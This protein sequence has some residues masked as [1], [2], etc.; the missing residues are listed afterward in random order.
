MENVI[1]VTGS[2]HKADY[3]SRCLGQPVAHQK[4]DVDEIQSLDLHEIV[5]HKVRGA[6][7]KVRQPVI[8]E[9]VSLEFTALGKLPGPFIKWFFQELG[10]EGVCSL[11][12]GK[13]RSATV[14]CV[15]G[16]YDGTDEQ[17]FEG[18]VTGRIAE[19]PHPGTGYGFDPIF[20][21]DGFDAPRSVMNAEDHDRTY[22][23]MKPFLKLKTYL[24]TKKSRA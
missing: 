21:H 2:Q 14:R 24:D 17:Y 9:D 12:D 19:K 7:E 22:L 5:R 23:D 15:V 13:D 11:L 20:I 16:Y 4:I 10:V 6:Y 1:F 8:V 3:L 18:V